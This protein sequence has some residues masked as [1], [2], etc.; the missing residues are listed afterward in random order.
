MLPIM[1]KTHYSSYLAV[2]VPNLPFYILYEC[3]TLDQWK[4]ATN[5]TDHNGAKMCTRTV[6]FEHMEKFYGCFGL[7]K[8]SRLEAL[9]KYGFVT[10]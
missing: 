8:I 2:P 1:F 7:R 9:I 6:I 10:E 3:E 5:Y 4:P